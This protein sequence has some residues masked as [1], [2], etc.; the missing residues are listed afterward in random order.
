MSVGAGSTITPAGGVNGVGK[1]PLVTYGIINSLTAGYIGV[2]VKSGA[3][4]AKSGGP[5]VGLSNSYG[6]T[7]PFIAAVLFSESVEFER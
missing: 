3:K 5:P 2:I 1:Y 7:E 4:S 6:C